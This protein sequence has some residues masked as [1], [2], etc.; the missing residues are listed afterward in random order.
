MYFTLT[1]EEKSSCGV[2]ACAYY[3]FQNRTEKLKCEKQMIF[4]VGIKKILQFSAKLWNLPLEKIWKTVL[5]LKYNFRF[6]NKRE[7]HVK[8]LHVPYYT[9]G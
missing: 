9:L 6:N 1:P 5:F 8:S 3:S 2:L 7:S 4:L